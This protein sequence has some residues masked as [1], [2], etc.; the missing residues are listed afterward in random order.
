MHG[1]RRNHP[2]E[3]AI[4]AQRESHVQQS[5][6]EGLAEGVVSGFLIMVPHVI[7]Q[8]QWLVE[9]DLFGLRLSHAMLLV[10]AGV[11]VVPIEAC[12]LLEIDHGCTLPSH[13]AVCDYPDD[14]RAIT[15]HGAFTGCRVCGESTVDGHATLRL[16]YSSSMTAQ[17]PH[18]TFI[19]RLKA[20]PF[21]EA[22]YLFGSRARGTQRERSDIDLAIVCPMAGVREWQA[23]L[24]IVEDADTL[25]HVD[26]VRLDAEPA[27]SALRRQI[28]KERLTLFLREAA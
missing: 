15:S 2:A 25:L 16:R 18:Y 21:V 9:E 11:A 14:Q 20:L 12:D 26:C 8:Q 23:V 22:I 27:D 24:D 13:T 6:G 7:L 1:A 28:E 3:S 17:L 5:P 10:L 19:D 4:T